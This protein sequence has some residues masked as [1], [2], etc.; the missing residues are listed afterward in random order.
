MGRDTQGSLG[1]RFFQESLVVVD[2]DLT[3]KDLRA[4]QVI[5]AVSGTPIQNF[6]IRFLIKVC[7]SLP[8]LYK[9]SRTGRPGRR[10]EEAKTLFPTD[11]RQARVILRQ[12]ATNDYYEAFEE[13]SHCLMHRT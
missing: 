8:S 5:K 7:R 12:V 1:Y 9:Q 4:G 3:Q 10:I 11:P 6:D 13:P 2:M